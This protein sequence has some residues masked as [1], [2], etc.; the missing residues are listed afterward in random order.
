MLEMNS[1]NDLIGCSFSGNDLLLNIK[2][3]LKTYQIR[4]QNQKTYGCI[5]ELK[6]ITIDG[7][8]SYQLIPEEY[9]LKQAQYFDEF[10]FKI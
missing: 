7:I 5:E 6:I 8:N 4:I 2:N 9:V 1:I 3:K 10:P